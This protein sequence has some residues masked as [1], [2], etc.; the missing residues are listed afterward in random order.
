[1]PQEHLLHIV[2][3][4][5]PARLG[6]TSASQGGSGKLIPNRNRGN[7]ADFLRNSLEIAWREAENEFITYHTDRQGV[8]LEFR[9]SP[10][11]DLAT[12]SLEN[13][14]SKKIRLCNIR[15]EKEVVLNNETGEPEEKPV[16]YATVFVAN[17]K[18][19]AFLIR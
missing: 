4:D 16:T 19:Q 7:H 12:K 18:R 13:M 14:K 11:Y 8:Y 5:P 15:T 2:L 9:G 1:M 6:F 10:G 3:L 17:D